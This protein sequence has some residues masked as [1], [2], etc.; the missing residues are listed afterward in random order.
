[1]TDSDWQ[2]R[3][4]LEDLTSEFS[5]S[6]KKIMKNLNR[7]KYNNTEVIVSGGTK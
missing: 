2:A 5:R 3:E 1:M 4:V 6:M 7:K